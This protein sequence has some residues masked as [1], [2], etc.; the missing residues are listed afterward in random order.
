MTFDELVRRI[1]AHQD[2]LASLHVHKLSVFGSVAR[3]EA[4]EASDVDL[5]VGF[6]RPVGLFHFVTVKERLEAVLAVSVDLVT[7]GGLK[8]PLRAHVLAEARRI[9]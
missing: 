4:G 8:A 1:A 6:D 2:E 5:L 9:A 3:G 7:P